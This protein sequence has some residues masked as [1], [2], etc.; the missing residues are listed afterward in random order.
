MNVDVEE[1]EDKR[2]KLKADDLVKTL[3][4]NVIKT[5]SEPKWVWR[6]NSITVINVPR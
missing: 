5:S 3:V 1:K 6:C 2:L 4:C